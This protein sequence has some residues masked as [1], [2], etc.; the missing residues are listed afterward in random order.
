M[1]TIAP[2]YSRWRLSRQDR[3]NLVKGL[4]FISP[5]LIGF[6]G[7]LAYPIFYTVRMSFTKYSG[8]GEAKWIGLQNYR[9]L[10]NDDVFWKAVYN[11][12]YYTGLAVPVGVV[13]AITLAVA[14]NQP[15]PEVRIYR[16]LFYLP[17]IIPIFTLTQTFQILMSPTQ[18]VFN[19]ILIFFGF[20]NINWFG[21]PAYSKLGL[22]ILAQYGAGQAAIIFLAGLKGIPTPLYEAASLDGATGW[23]RF[24][25]ITIPLLTPVILYDIIIG[26]S[27][28]LQV[29]T[30]IYI[31]GG[32][33]PGG[34]ANSTIS[35]VLYLYMNGFTYGK[36]GYA[37][38]MAW[39]LF[40]V[41]GILAGLIFW[42]SKK[43]V[44]YDTV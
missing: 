7:L 38:A 41:T 16:A 43:W 36:F 44:N 30:Q 21:N 8:F 19:R 18:G 6:F 31:L 14:M 39:I 34:P 24:W 11:T 5:W 23:R 29:F 26:I 33:P 1:A 42:S 10:M 17:S 4:L 32:N 27:G 35:Y 28:G 12:L 2:R 40:I 9:D 13:V 37:A 25:N 22:V 15:M 20:P 3:K